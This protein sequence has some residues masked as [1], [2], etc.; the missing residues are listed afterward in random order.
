[1]TDLREQRAD[2]RRECR[3]PALP[4]RARRR[5]LVGASDDDAPRVVGAV[6]CIV[7]VALVVRPAAAAVVVVVRPAAAVAC[8]GHSHALRSRALSH[9]RRHIAVVGEAPGEQAA[10]LELARVGLPVANTD[11]GDELRPLISM[12]SRTEL[13]SIVPLIAVGRSSSRV[14]RRWESPSRVPRF[15]GR[16]GSGK[17]ERRDHQPSVAR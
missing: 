10:S 7:V 2:A 8:G 16:L 15:K 13:P 5:R 17:R 14:R 12:S 11:A 6:A 3:L 9:P 4:E 1:V